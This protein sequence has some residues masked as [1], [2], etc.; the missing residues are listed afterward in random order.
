MPEHILT[1]SRF[2]SDCEHSDRSGL[3]FPLARLD[4]IPRTISPDLTSLL[5]TCAVY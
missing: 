1:R 4:G 3:D 5:Q 2:R